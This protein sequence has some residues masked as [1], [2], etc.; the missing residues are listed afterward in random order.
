M[1]DETA[2]HDVLMA[3]IAARRAHAGIIGLGYVQRVR[4][5]QLDAFERRIRDA[6]RP[7]FRADRAGT[8]PDV[9]LVTHI[10]PS[11]ENAAALG[12]DLGAIPHR[13]AAAEQAMR[14]RQ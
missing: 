8:S 9:L 12:Q 10:E 4:R 13:R 11:A 5:D 3:K 1:N 6:G 7:E 14:W 2:I